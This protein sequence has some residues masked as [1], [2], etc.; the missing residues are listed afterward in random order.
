MSTPAE[1]QA[2]AALKAARGPIR[3]WIAEHPVLY[4]EGWAAVAVLAFILAK[5]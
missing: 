2:I 4:T 3:A 5:L 1:Q